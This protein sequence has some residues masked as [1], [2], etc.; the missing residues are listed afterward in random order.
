MVRTYSIVLSRHLRPASRVDVGK[1]CAYLDLR[2]AVDLETM[3]QL[4]KRAD[5]FTT[6]YRAEVNR[7]FGLLPA[8]LA[9]ASERGI[10]CMYS[11]GG[12][13]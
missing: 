12:G 2:D 3:R 9:A 7:R 5:V 13:P 1:R 4:A 10:A 8:K 11:Y 6:T